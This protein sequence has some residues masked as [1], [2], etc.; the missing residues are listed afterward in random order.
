MNGRA[1][2]EELEIPEFV[3]TV[4]PEGWSLKEEQNLERGS[5]GPGK[6]VDGARPL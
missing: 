3:L 2:N 4:S 1:G 6:W 5:G